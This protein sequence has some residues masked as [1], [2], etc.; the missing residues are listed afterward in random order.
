LT[1]KKKEGG[2][3]GD[4]PEGE[5]AG[6]GEAAISDRRVRKPAKP[7]KRGS[8]ATIKKKLADKERNINIRIRQGPS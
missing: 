6:D 2:Q 7:R 4:M 8:S 3:I 5:A 1:K